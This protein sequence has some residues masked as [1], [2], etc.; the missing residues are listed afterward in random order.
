VFILENKKK[1]KDFYENISEN[2]MFGD[3]CTHLLD[4]IRSRRQEFCFK[5]FYFNL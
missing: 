1:K 4:G 3:T 2:L 5:G